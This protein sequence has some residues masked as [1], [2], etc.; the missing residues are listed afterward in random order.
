MRQRLP[1]NKMQRTSHG[2]DGGS[3]LILVLGGR[4]E[5]TVMRRLRTTVR[6]AAASIL[7]LGTLLPAA[8]ADEVRTNGPESVIER[9]VLAW[10]A[11]DMNAFATLFTDDA[12][13]VPVAE[14]RLEGR[15]N[16]VAD[17]Q[18][19]HE[20]WARTVSVAISGKPNIR[21]LRPDVGV[22]LCH[23]GYPDTDGALSRPGNALMIIAVKESNEWRIA[24]GQITKPKRVSPPR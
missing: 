19:A 18:R 1:N 2:Q 22:I 4:E 12:S 16:I 15:T 7:L 23:V 13:W 5:W 9:F 10:N 17:L 8:Q 6:Q 21:L 24:A 3:P 11:H 14:Q 20:S